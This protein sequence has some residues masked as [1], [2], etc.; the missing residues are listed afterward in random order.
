MNKKN[1]NGAILIG[2][3]G[4]AL[5]ALMFVYSGKGGN[6]VRVENKPAEQ[7]SEL[8]AAS[9]AELEA[10]NKELEK[11]ISEIQKQLDSYTESEGSHGG[12]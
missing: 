2:I 7:M 1:K 12:Y 8:N 11:R 10:Q 9:D 6:D 3:L 4:I 5:I